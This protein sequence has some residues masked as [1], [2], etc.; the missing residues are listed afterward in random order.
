VGHWST[1]S[2]Q[3]PNL[4]LSAWE[5]AC[6]ALLTTVFA[7]QKLFALSVSVRY[8]PS[9]TVLPGTQR[10]RPVW[11]TATLLLGLGQYCVDAGLIFC[12]ADTLGRFGLRLAPGLR[13]ALGVFAVAGHGSL[14]LG[15]GVP[16]C[17]PDSP[18]EVL[19]FAS[20]DV[21]P[22]P[23]VWV[24]PHLA[25]V[26]AETHPMTELPEPGVLAR[27]VLLQVRPTAADGDLHFDQSFAGLVDG[28]D[29]GDGAGI[30]P[31]GIWGV[32]HAVHSA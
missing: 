18:D 30:V 19:K 20:R 27:A 9:Q 28:A 22:D 25:L 17:L 6:H 15:V 1:S 21:E 23:S 12:Q 10:A 16:R 4:G 11:S 5:L 8:R 31:E 3:I 32:D 24:D 2:P 29:P 13:L 14:V 26:P 7:V